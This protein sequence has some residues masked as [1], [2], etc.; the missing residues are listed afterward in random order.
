MKNT[1]S[2]GFTL[3]ELVIAIAI[4]GILAAVAWPYYERE[5]MKQRRS[6]ALRALT[7]AQAEMER[8]R[9]D[10]GVYAAAGLSTTESPRKY[11]TVAAATTNAGENYTLTAEAKAGGIQFSDDNCRKFIV[12]DLG[13]YSSEKSDTTASTNCIP[14]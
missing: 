5:A 1:N 13:Q 9:S 7:T 3:I 10:N 14:K 8:Y 4:V 12:N 2:N 6:D 11:Y